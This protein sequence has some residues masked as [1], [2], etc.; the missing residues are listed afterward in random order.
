MGHLQNVK[1]PIL[2]RDSTISAL[3]ICAKFYIAQKPRTKRKEKLMLPYAIT[4]ASILSNVL[5]EE[6]MFNIEL[7]PAVVCF[8][9]SILRFELIKIF[10]FIIAR[11]CPAGLK[12]QPCI[13]RCKRT[14]RN[15]YTPFSLDECKSGCVP[16]CTCGE[17][18]YFD[19]K[20]NRCVEKKDCSCLH[21]LSKYSPGETIKD[22]CNTCKCDHGTWS[23]TKKQCAK[24][25]QI[26]GFQHL[27]T[28]DGNTFD[29]RGDN[30]RYTLV[31]RNTAVTGKGNLHIAYTMDDCTGMS[32]TCTKSVF[33]QYDDIAV[34]L[35]KSGR[36]VVS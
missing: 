22:D 4:W 19:D 5:K 24:K 10:S 12:Y 14:C 31:E 27:E 8:C 21:N 7:Q 1:Q 11:E 9:F 26:I 20:V 33:V 23:C 2:Q 16:G 6:N 32:I 28:F 29:L 13:N 25:C 15:L 34:V 3:T 36:F 18:T 17:G 30:C 35:K